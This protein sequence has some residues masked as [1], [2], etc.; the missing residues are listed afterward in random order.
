MVAKIKDE[1]NQELD[2]KFTK[3]IRKTMDVIEDRIENGN[4][5]FDPKTGRVLRIPV[6]LRDTHRVMAD[7][8][9][10]RRVIRNQPTLVEENKNQMND[11]LLSLAEQ[12]AKF[13]LGKQEDSMKVVSGTEVYENDSS[14][15]Q[16]E[17]LSED[18]GD[19][20]IPAPT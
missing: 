10:K 8:V 5:Q 12:F 4:Y 14:M 11:R 19:E 9:D 18:N 16:L 1:D 2:T 17:P 13:A 7:L 20:V 15:T 6:N 3:I